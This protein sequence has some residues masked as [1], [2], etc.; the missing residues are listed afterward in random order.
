MLFVAI[1]ITGDLRVELFCYNEFLPFS[2]TDRI[3]DFSS[4]TFNKNKEL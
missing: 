1:N 3:Q 4:I 2:S